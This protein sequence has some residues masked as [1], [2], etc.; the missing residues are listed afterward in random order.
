MKLPGFPDFCLN[1]MCLETHEVHLGKGPWACNSSLLFLRFGTPIWGRASKTSKWFP[2]HSAN[3]KFTLLSI[4]IKRRVGIAVEEQVGPHA[5]EWNLLLLSFWSSWVWLCGTL[6]LPEGFALH[7][8]EDEGTSVW[9]SHPEWSPDRWLPIIIKELGRVS[10][11]FAHS[12][13]VPIWSKCPDLFLGKHFTLSPCDSISAG[14]GT[15]SHLSESSS[16][17]L[18]L[19]KIIG[20]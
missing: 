20:E 17:L 1:Y 18:F 11:V 8:S 19:M 4:R 6:S 13:S 7:S 2:G 3:I 15:W 9:C 10:I 14:S 16:P 12:A 5:W